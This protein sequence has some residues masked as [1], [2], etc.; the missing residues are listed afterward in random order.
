MG[1]LAPYEPVNRLKPVAED[2]WIVDGPEVRMRY[3]GLRLPFTTRMTI[4]RLPDGRLF[5]HSPTEL[6]V[7]LRQDVASLGPV[8][9]LVSPNRLHTTWLDAWRRA[10]P[11]AQ[12]AGVAAEP[13]WDGTRLR[14]ALN[15][16][17]PGPFPWA[18]AIAQ[19]LVPGGM[20][21]EAVFFHAPSRSLILT[22]LI[23]NFELE[24]V[25][26]RWLR[27][28]LRVTGPLHPNGTAPPD[29]RWTFRRHKP[30]LRAALAL[31]RGWAPE[32]IIFA[33]GRWY[34]SDGVRE[35][36]RA[37]RWVG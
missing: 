21:S 9:F 3:A 17:G 25:R 32:R 18:P 12:T 14:A 8:G 24:R 27:L 23:E 29:M 37:F 2:L 35:L 10:W 1:C 15:L 13:A 22:D 5:V 30:A 7:T 20:F 31:M 28:V 34:P 4:V 33:H 26:C 36:N 19:T 16:G 6:T 11:E